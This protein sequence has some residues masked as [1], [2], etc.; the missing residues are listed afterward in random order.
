[1]VDRAKDVVMDGRWELQQQHAGLNHRLND[2]D[3]DLYAKLKSLER[4]LEFLEIQV[5]LFRPISSSVDR[6]VT[7]DSS[8]YVYE[9]RK[10]ILK[11]SKRISRMSCCVR[12]R[13]LSEFKLYQL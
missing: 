11:K 6:G 12:K 1:M 2:G 9:R 5:C 13:K 4:Q 7:L 8:S 10:N 3:G